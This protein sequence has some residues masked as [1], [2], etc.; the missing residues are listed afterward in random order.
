MAGLEDW[1]VPGS[2]PTP[3]SACALELEPGAALVENDAHG[4]FERLGDQVVTGPTLTNV[5]DLRAVLIQ[6][7]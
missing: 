2:G 7:A 6:G 3:W 4:I 5:N 1:P